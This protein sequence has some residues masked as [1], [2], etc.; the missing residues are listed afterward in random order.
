M[1][2]SNCARLILQR[3]DYRRQMWTQSSIRMRKTCSACDVL[4]D[5]FSRGF[6]KHSP[7]EGM[8]QV[9]L[10]L[11]AAFVV[12]NQIGRVS[13]CVGSF[14]QPLLDFSARTGQQLFGVE[15]AR[16]KRTDA[17]HGNSRRCECESSVGRL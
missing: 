7:Q 2:L 15:A 9:P 4:G 11:G 13:N 14:G 1:T 17:A 3:L 5:D 16:R 8:N 12:L 10:V 6:S